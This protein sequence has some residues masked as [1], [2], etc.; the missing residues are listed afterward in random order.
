MLAQDHVADKLRRL[1]HKRSGRHLRR[2]PLVGTDHLGKEVERN[3]EGA[4][5]ASATKIKVA[6]VVLSEGACPSR[7][8]AT[9]RGAPYHPRE[10]LPRP[11]SSERD[12]KTP[13]C[14]M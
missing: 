14:S 8:T 2:L 4:K 10:F 13:W 9:L 12:L 1:V 6:P 11:G 7:N 3:T 5:A